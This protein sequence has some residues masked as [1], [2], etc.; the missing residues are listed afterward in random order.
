MR[1]R[2]WSQAAAA[3]AQVPLD[4]RDAALSLKH[5]LSTNLAALQQHR[6]AVYDL[7]LSL[8]A[9]ARIRHRRDC[10]R[11][12][13][14]QLPAPRWHRRQLH[15]RPRPCRRRC[16]RA[17]QDLPADPRGRSDRPVWHRRR[18]PDTAARAATAVTVHGQAAAGVSDRAGAA[19]RAAVP[20]DPR[21]HG[22]AGP[23][24]HERFH[25]FVG[26]GWD[27]AIERKLLDDPFLPWASVTVSQ[28]FDTK[29]IQAALGPL[30]SACW[31]VMR[32]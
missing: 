18:I 14:D 13:V 21:L 2:Q 24:E 11:K 29:H 27:Q 30:P 12:A 1:L 23:I 15:R 8:P 17:S 26:G 7:L 25:W 10:L 22:R 9:S 5:R 16:C 3:F 4:A 32:T 31:S 6:P 28:G 19:D 20:D